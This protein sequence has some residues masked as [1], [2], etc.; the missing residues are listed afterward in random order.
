MGRWVYNKKLMEPAQ[1]KY[2]NTLEVPRPGFCSVKS[3][4]NLS[5]DPGKSL[6]ATLVAKNFERYEVVVGSQ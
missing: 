4:A 3:A 6:V 1:W 2:G 5:A